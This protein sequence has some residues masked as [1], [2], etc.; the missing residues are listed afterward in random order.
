MRVILESQRKVPRLPLY[1]RVQRA[2]L[3][4]DVRAFGKAMGVYGA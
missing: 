1:I 3:A 4:E 2:R